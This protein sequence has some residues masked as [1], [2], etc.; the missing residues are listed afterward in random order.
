MKKFSIL[1]VITD[2][3]G[4]I[5]D[6]MPFILDKF[7]DF[8]AR[9]GVPRDFTKQYIVDNAGT[10]TKEQIKGILAANNQYPLE[11]ELIDLAAGYRK[12][13]AGAPPNIF[14]GAP[15]TLRKIK[16]SGRYLL[17]TSGTDTAELMRYFAR[18]SLPYDMVLG[19][20]QVPKGDEHIRLFASH[21][22][23]GLR[24]FCSQ[25]VLIGDGPADMEIAKRN[26]ILAVG[27]T[28][29]VSRQRLL[30]EG[31]SFI[32]SNISELPAILN[33]EA[34]QESF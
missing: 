9:F 29:T 15:E 27:I 14:P 26:R 31:A 17:A 23:L 12:T 18:E 4:T 11:K 25:A 21:F 5:F 34:G 16:E 1:F 8:L 13:V 3:D 6:R 20:D 7:A 30:D 10:P 33:K 28:T 22:G 24:E 32:I 19:S 2:I